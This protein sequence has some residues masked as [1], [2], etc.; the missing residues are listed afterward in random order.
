MQD[1]RSILILLLLLPAI[2]L[3]QTIHI[4][5]D[6]IAYE[7]KINVSGDSYNRAK[8]LILNFA[9]PDST[10][11]DKDD[12]KFSSVVK[13]KLPSEY[14]LQKDLSYKLLLHVTAGQIEYEIKDVQLTLYERGEK[15]KVLS[16]EQ[17]LKGMDESGNTARDTEKMLDDIDMYIQQFLARLKT[18]GF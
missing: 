6:E 9:D 11:E 2:S 16:S 1:I 4:K 7:G 13:M 17:L 10:K 18:F 12:K 8:S 5:K 3:G 14:H 15:P